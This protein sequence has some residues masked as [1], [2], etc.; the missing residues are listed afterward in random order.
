M[1][2]KRKEIVIDFEHVF[3]KLTKPYEDLDPS[4]LSAELSKRSLY[5]PKGGIIDT[6]ALLS[7]F[8]IEDM[9]YLPETKYSN[10][11]ECLKPVGEWQQYLQTAIKKPQFIIPHPHNGKPAMTGTGNWSFRVADCFPQRKFCI[12]ELSQVSLEG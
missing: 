11:K 7:F 6:V 2:A 1:N 4:Q 10:G 5:T 3:D 9:L 12:V 8:N